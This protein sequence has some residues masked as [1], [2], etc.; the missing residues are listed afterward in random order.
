MWSI[1]LLAGDAGELIGERDRQQIAVRETLGSSFDP[2]PLSLHG[3]GGT[4][5]EDDV[6]SLNEQRPEVFVATLG[7]SAE[8]GAIS[9]RLLLRHEAELGAEITALVEAGA[10]ADCRRHR[11]RDDRTNSRNRHQALT[12]AVVLSQ[13]LDF[14]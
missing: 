1:L 5:Y 12:A 6:G 9:G 2:R 14:A 8:L 3:R 13:G 4:S 11:A 7:D 10:V